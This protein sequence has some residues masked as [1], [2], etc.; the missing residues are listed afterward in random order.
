MIPELD[1]IK[2]TVASANDILIIQADNPDG[3]SLGSALA[4]EQIFGDMGKNP[5]MYCGVD[6]PHY[7]RFLD[8]WDRVSKDI[9]SK[10]DTS[11]IVDT[12]AHL[13]LDQLE[14]T[15][16]KTWVAAKPV[17]LIDHHINVT[18]DIPYATIICNAPDFVATGE[19]IYEIVKTLK[20]PLNLS[21][22]EFLTQSILSDSLGLT[23][24]GTTADTYRRMAEM[25]D[26]GVSRVKLEEAR[27]ALSKMPQSVFQYKAKL[28][29]RTE[30]YGDNSEIAVV[31]IPEEE[32]F[33]V[34]TLYNPAPL[35]LNEMTMVEGVLVG[36]VLKRYSDKTT[37]AIRCTNGAN[38]AHKIAESFGGGGHPYAAGFKMEKSTTNFGELKCEV[39]AKTEELLQLITDD[40]TE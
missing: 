35:I 10:I 36:I 7:I 21:S 32:L 12:S 5:S 11:I 29:E 13:L 14:K 39:I 8:G 18:C 27:R 2:E 31:S 24:D 30:F 15:P 26:A 19:V 37:G 4:L 1:R 28:I 20:W 33:T 6:I 34:G 17:I 38:I 40:A 16:A 23:S 22:Y 25:L 3:D 9:P